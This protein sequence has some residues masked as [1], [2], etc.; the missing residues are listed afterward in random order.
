MRSCSR[1][2]LTNCPWPAVALLA[3][4][5]GCA[6]GIHRLERKVDA[7]RAQMEREVSDMFRASQKL[8]AGY[9][10]ALAGHYDR[11]IELYKEARDISPQLYNVHNALG[12]AY[13]K[14]G[15]V[16]DA[17]A[18]FEEAKR[19]HPDKI[20]SYADLAVAYTKAGRQ[21]E[22]IEAIEEVL[23]RDPQQIEVYR[24]KAYAPLHNNLRF[25]Q[26]LSTAYYKGSP[27]PRA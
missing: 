27:Q 10:E 1:D 13:L 20:E 23:R 4:G 3:L 24:S 9:Q 17:A 11:A 16:N 19:W 26:L 14:K 2:T 12:W 18:A 22:A 25:Q 15:C 7:M 8:Q 5:L 6:L 21:R